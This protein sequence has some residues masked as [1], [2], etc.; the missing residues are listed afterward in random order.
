MIEKTYDKKKNIYQ[1]IILI[2]T[3]IFFLILFC[4]FYMIYNPTLPIRYLRNKF[5]II[6]DPTILRDSTKGYIFTS[7]IEPNKEKKHKLQ[8]FTGNIYIYENEMGVKK[9]RLI[10]DLP[11]GAFISSSNTFQAYK[12]IPD[13]DIAVA[14][15]EY[16][17]L[18][19][20][21]SITAI[22]YIEQA[23][24]FIIDVFK[25]DWKVDKIQVYLSTASAGT[26]YGVKIINNMMFKDCISKFA[27]V[28][29]YFGI[30]TTNHI[31]AK[32]VDGVYLRK[33]K[34]N[35]LFDCSPLPE[36][37]VDTFFAVAKGDPLAISTH[38]F[39]RT[40]SQSD[41]IMEYNSSAHCF[42]L[43]FNEDITK[44]YYKDLR[45]FFYA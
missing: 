28:N 17:V 10:I 18:P 42:Y 6:G 19:A 36:G 15:I 35:N 2:L 25:Q 44:Q 27:S 41:H 37:I 29:G 23:M 20:G 45:E 30:K 32:I 39:V 4:V 31:M 16:P 40:T 24:K 5:Q 8:A 11:G 9:D 21:D 26:Y 38:N 1:T 33:L 7:T 43:H 13:F 34:K 14:S 12:H 22:Y 3:V